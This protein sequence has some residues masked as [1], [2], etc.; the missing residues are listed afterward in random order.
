MDLKYIY[1]FL[2]TF[3]VYMPPSPDNQLWDSSLQRQN[4][5]QEL[6]ADSYFQSVKFFWGYTRSGPGG[7][8]ISDH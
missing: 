4:T 3:L 1:L 5:G 7:T 6:P 2:F 8:Q